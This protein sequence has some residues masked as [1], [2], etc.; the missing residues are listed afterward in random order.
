M[1]ILYASD[2]NI[3]VRAG[4]ARARPAARAPDGELRPHG[5]SLFPRGGRPVPGVARDAD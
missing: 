2:V 5:F 3:G 1:L 4:Y